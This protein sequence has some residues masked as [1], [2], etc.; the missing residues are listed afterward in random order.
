MVSANR[1]EFAQALAQAEK[2]LDS[3]QTLEQARSAIDFVLN[4]HLL[5]FLGSMRFFL[6]HTQTRLTRHYGDKSVPLKTFKA[7]TAQAYD[8]EFA[9]RF[10]YKLRNYAQ[11]CAMPIGHLQLE[12]KGGQGGQRGRSLILG[13]DISELLE[14]GDEVWGAPLKAEL[15]ALPV[16]LDVAP[17]IDRVLV[18][19]TAVSDAVE[20]SERPL[21][22]SVAEI[23]VSLGQPVVDAG[24]RPVVGVAKGKKLEIVRLPY[25]VLSWLGHAIPAV[26][27]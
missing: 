12:T 7:R 26:I 17:L 23:I 3:H 15:K 25:E 2:N 8:T 6:D 11:H 5:N 10:T 27:V 18:E 1:D 21:L 20:Q 4:R 24:G 13:F 16:L 9:Y 14:Q 22:S 19:L